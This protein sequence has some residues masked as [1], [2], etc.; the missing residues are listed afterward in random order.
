MDNCRSLL[1]PEMDYL[2]LDILKIIALYLDWRDVINFSR[3]A[4]KYRSIH[5]I[6]L[7]QQKLI[8]DRYMP[9]IKYHNPFCDY[10]LDIVT[11]IRWCPKDGVK[12]EDEELFFGEESKILAKYLKHKYPEK[13]KFYHFDIY[14]DGLHNS[15]EIL[16]KIR[17]GKCNIVH[18]TINQEWEQFLTETY[19][20]IDDNVNNVRISSNGCYETEEVGA[21]LE[22]RDFLSDYGLSWKSAEWLYLSDT[23]FT[24]VNL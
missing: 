5:N 10:L 15:W 14:S 16:E 24:F 7:W 13:F 2:P 17:L 6:K 12:R 3:V 8:N 9:D 22:F 19:F 1:L 20:M 4:K 21:S 18:I 11:G 23:K